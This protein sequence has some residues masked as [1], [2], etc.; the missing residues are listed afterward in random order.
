[1][2]VK[3]TFI[4]GLKVIQPKVFLDER[5][6]FYESY[7]QE[8]FEKLGLT[9]RFVQDNES[10]SSKGVLR[11]LHFQKPPYSQGKLLRVVNGA[12]LD[13]AVDLRKNSKT[14]GKHYSII[15]SKDNKTMF[16]IPEGFAHGFLTLEDKTIFDYKCTN[17]YHP[18]SE[19]GII[20]ND[21]TLAIDW[22]IDNPIISNKD[23]KNVNFKDFISPF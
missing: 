16:Y 19:G 13:V 3:D 12:V 4:E 22:K 7:N 5:G 1:M 2:E 8:T 10:Q 21:V 9:M 18:E 11:G 6:Y 15:L 14:Y 20:W 23:A 17:V